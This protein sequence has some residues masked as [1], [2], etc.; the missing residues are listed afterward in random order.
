[1]NYYELLLWKGTQSELRTGYTPSTDEL[2]A[3]GGMERVFAWRRDLALRGGGDL[4]LDMSI[5]D[6][7]CQPHLPALPQDDILSSGEQGG[8][9]VVPL[10]KTKLVLKQTLTFTALRRLCPGLQHIYPSLG[11]TLCLALELSFTTRRCIAFW[12][13]RSGTLGVMRSKERGASE[14][15][16]RIEVIRQDQ[17]CILLS[18]NV[19]ISA[20]K[21]HAI[22]TSTHDRATIRRSCKPHLLPQA[23]D[24]AFAP[25]SSACT[26]PHIVSSS[27]GDYLKAGEAV[28]EVESWMDRTWK[29]SIHPVKSKYWFI[30]KVVTTSTRET[31]WRRL[32]K[33]CSLLFFFGQIGPTTARLGSP[34]ERF[35][36]EV[37]HVWGTN[38]RMTLPVCASDE[39]LQDGEIMVL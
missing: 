36:R 37:M 15:S 3:S 24:G 30:V 5:T 35:E 11:A 8:F 6:R 18:D 2:L 28:K 12:Q 26:P 7:T 21:G 39:Y 23:H 25:P 9:K 10:H 29:S 14:V 13:A 22:D 31:T 16:G 4:M 27:V 1:M 32:T 20:S 33:G 17:Q 38:G 19:S 34:L